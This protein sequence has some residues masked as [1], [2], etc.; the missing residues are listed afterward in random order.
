MPPR[1]RRDPFLAE[2]QK[3]QS[4]WQQLSAYEEMLQ[5]E[6]QIVD[7]QME[8]L[9]SV[10][11]ALDEEE[12]QREE[13]QRLFE[14]YMTRFEWLFREA[15]VRLQLILEF[16]LLLYWSQRTDPASSW[17]PE[18]D[19]SWQNLGLDAGYP[20]LPALNDPAISAAIHDFTKFQGVD[21]DTF[22][23][24]GDQKH[25]EEVHN[26]YPYF[27]QPQLALISD[28]GNQGAAIYSAD[29]IDDDIGVLSDSAFKVDEATW[30]TVS[31]L[32]NG[33]YRKSGVFTAAHGIDL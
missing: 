32:T 33:R 10:E 5:A 24:T 26:R 17:G 7:L 22:A 9:M 18:L 19:D 15:A 4:Y 21:A 6:L 20:S 30:T 25:D 23:Q 14:S 31:Q 3:A 16:L 28:Q 29:Q 8:Q 13:D 12:R 11:D 27:K 2:F 1:D